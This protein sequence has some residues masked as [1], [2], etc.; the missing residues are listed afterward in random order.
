M[1]DLQEY[2]LEIK[3][4][5]AIKGHGLYILA[6]EVVHTVENEEELTSWE[7]EIEMYDIR[8]ATPIENVTSWYTNVCQYLEH[9]TIP[10]HFSIR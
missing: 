2:D 9:G 10:S 1:V 5:H 4:L 7:Q 8:R 6:A 3:P